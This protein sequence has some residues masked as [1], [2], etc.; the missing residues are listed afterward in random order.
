MDG[1]RFDDRFLDELKLKN[2][3]VTV[4]NGYVPLEKKGKTYWG[5]C[6][7]HSEKTPSFA[8]N[9]A[10]QYYHCFGCKASGNVIKFVME[11]ESMTFYDAVKML[12]ER[13][14]MELPKM[15]E[16]GENFEKHKKEREQ[17]LACL[18]SAARHYHDN[19]K[20]SEFA[21]AY[22]QGRRISPEMVVKFGI[23]YSLDYNEIITYLKGQGFSLDIMKKVGIVK[24]KDGRNYDALGER[25]VFP[26]IN[27]YGDVVAFSGRT[28]KAK[29]DYAKYINTAETPV[30]TKGKN[31]FGINL[32]KK[33]KQAGGIDRLI[34]VEGQIDVIALH[35]AGY[36]TAIASLGTALTV[37]QARLM[38][39]LSD[40]VVI[41]YDGDF[42]GT[43]A[44]LR[45]LDIL[46]HEK[47]N[48]RVASIP[49]GLDP[50]EFIL[51]RGKA[52]FDKIIENAKPLIEY[53]L[54]YLKSQYDLS[55]FD[56]KT[57]FVEEALA[58][59]S[60]LSE[61]EAE[62][63]FDYIR[64][65]TGVGKDFLRNK[66]YKDNTLKLSENMFPKTAITREKRVDNKIRQA[67]YVVLASL[68]RNKKYAQKSPKLADYFTD[69]LAELL[70]GIL[71]GM[72]V[73][74][75]IE[76]FEGEYPEAVGEVVNYDF[77]EDETV[78][79]TCYNDCLWVLCKEH[80]L[81]R[82]KELMG[83]MSGLIG[84]DKKE[85]MQELYFIAQKINGKKVDL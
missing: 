69:E 64:D 80:L 1:Y 65:C 11:M 50:D 59:L 85:V 29:V 58:V 6:P 74:E 23:G 15:A 33:A 68:L 63:Y 66:L 30:F 19:L 67:E 37:D 8:V 17:M 61:V 14:N 77:A 84:E 9:E 41:C 54:A 44:T 26:I 2:N 28:T 7:F 42:A 10:D 76:K 4:I 60:G 73:P 79:E 21:R 81:A 16:D 47:I 82:Q 13:A 43:K 70:N 52:A 12:A 57:K 25:I 56:G 22:L 45:G 32:A 27:I 20:K 31:L 24:E 49:D 75:F 71:G 55:D 78:N 34:I 35:G 40:N 51:K 53:K 5:R 83:K 62:V 46:K 38:K 36:G 39:R 48:V 3:I 18:K 72:G